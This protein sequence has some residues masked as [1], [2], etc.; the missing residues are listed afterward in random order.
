MKKIDDKNII[1]DGSKYIPPHKRSS[2]STLAS[3]SISEEKNTPAKN[4]KNKIP[5]ESKYIPPHK[6]S[7]QTFLASSS[8]SEKNN[9]LINSEKLPH[10]SQVTLLQK[11]IQLSAA[12]LS[13]TSHALD[14]QEQRNVSN[15]EIS[16]AIV[17]GV[18]TPNTSSDTYTTKDTIVVLSNQGKIITVRKNTANTYN[19]ITNNYYQI[20]QQL[21][22][23]IKSK[24]KSDVAMCELAEI[25]LSGNL[26]IRNVVAARDLL[27]QAIQTNKYNSHAMCMLAE[28]YVFNDLGAPDLEKAKFYWKKSADNNNKYG[29]YMCAQFALIDYIKNK[30]LLS[31]ASGSNA[32]LQKEIQKYLYKANSRGGTSSMWLQGYIFEK[33]YFGKIKLEKAI[34]FYTRAANNGQVISIECL[35]QLFIKGVISPERF[36]LI[37]EKISENIS[38]T[39]SGSAVEIGL[40]QAYGLLGNNKDRG[41]NIITKA[42]E[43]N[44]IKAMYA[45]AKCYKEGIGCD[46]NMEKSNFWSQ[47]A[48]EL[49]KE[50]G[51]N[52]NIYALWDLGHAYLS[53]I[54]GNIDLDKAREVFTNIANI[55][56]N[57]PFY[58]FAL[59]RFYLEGVLGDINPEVGN[60]WILKAKELWS[61]KA[62][63]GNF[64]AKKILDDIKENIQHGGV[65]LATEGL[66]DI[67]AK[68]QID[69]AELR[70]LI[71]M[72]NR[73]RRQ[74][75]CENVKTSFFSKVDVNNEIFDI[76]TILPPEDIFNMGIKIVDSE[77]LLAA[78]YFRTAAKCNYQ[79]AYI[80]LAQLYKSGKLGRNV[81]PLHKLFDERAAKLETYYSSNE[82]TFSSSAN[83]IR[84]IKIDTELDLLS[85]I[86]TSTAAKGDNYNNLNFTINISNVVEALSPGNS[87]EGYTTENADNQSSTTSASVSSNNRM[88]F[89]LP[90]FTIARR[91][92]NALIK[93]TAKPLLHG[94]H[95]KQMAIGVPQNVLQN[96]TRLSC[97]SH[98][99]NIL[100]MR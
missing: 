25:Y 76:E 8:I 30:N 10:S 96:L 12:T 4:D 62:D 50:G 14:R 21:L 89:S 58:K 36:E 9:T 19:N 44:N 75:M 31:S 1:P 60:D 95:V 20:E 93:N 40:Q 22:A 42:A 16:A 56:N 15:K 33:G 70:G 55:E 47:K 84:V 38:L 59:G 34:S 80:E 64:E 29:A 13:F 52:G 78:H 7:N 97:N 3:T 27:L 24:Q 39:N 83:E 51:K 67:Y 77:P 74:I 5:G 48:I 54:L 37:L 43:N 71:C 73:A 99:T 94:Y 87:S 82:E 32:E 66:P 28:L 26:G 91:N 79:K 46:I 69:N 53:G 41:I 18:K 92:I 90:S 68:E 2:K 57:N 17:G 6:R 81:Q 86:Q 98:R 23:K 11:N 100:K 45:L 61:L 72:L 65:I 49:A 88:F 85:Q 63:A 35:H